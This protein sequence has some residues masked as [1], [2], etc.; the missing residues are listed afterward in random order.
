M[1]VLADRLGV[2]KDLRSERISLLGNVADL[3]EEWQIKVAFDIALGAGIP[4]PI[5]GAAK[6]TGLLDNAEVVDADLLQP[7]CRQHPAKAAADNNHFEVFVL[8]I[9]REAWFNVRIRIEVLE[10][11]GNFPVLPVAIGTQPL[12]AFGS[13]SFPQ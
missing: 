11:T 5:P 1:E 9:A 8:R 3:F 12:G 2:G 6:I 13:I 10:L 4:V 7:N